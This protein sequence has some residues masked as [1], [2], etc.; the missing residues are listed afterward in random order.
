MVDLINV[1]N[2]RWKEV[3][4]DLCDHLSLLDCSL[5]LRFPSRDH[6]AIAY[7]AHGNQLYESFEAPA[8]GEITLPTPDT[9]VV[10]IQE[11]TLILMKI[12]D[13]TKSEINQVEKML[14]A[15]ERKLNAYHFQNVSQGLLQCYQT[16]MGCLNIGVFLVNV[17]GTIAYQNPEGRNLLKHHK[18]ITY[19]NDRLS[20]ADVEY[21]EQFHRALEYFSAMT[22]YYPGQSR[23][24]IFQIECRCGSFIQF[25]FQRY[26]YLPE[27]YYNEAVPKVL[28]LVSESP[29]HFN[30]S[31]EALEKV[32]QVSGRTGDLMHSIVQGQTL[33]HYADDR[34][35]AIA[36]VRNYL[37]AV[38]AQ[39]GVHRQIDLLRLADRSVLNFCIEENV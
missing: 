39:T 38:F 13:F 20:F 9:L 29:N 3:L 17:D 23:Q 12:S 7:E 32:Y 15:I 33:N 10:N 24:E 16:L 27:D 31:R 8:H 36:T 19:V 28:L 22:K 4:I 14:P 11:T 34:G 26:N 2:A 18:A 6:D 1:P 37:K 25:L 21:S 30:V 5:V 35:I